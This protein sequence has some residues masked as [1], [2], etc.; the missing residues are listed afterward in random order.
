[1][2]QKTINIHE[3]FE[4][5]VARTAAALGKPVYFDFGHESDVTTALKEKAEVHEQRFPLVW[6]VMDFEE[7]R[8]TE[9]GLYADLSPIMLIVC[10]PAEPAD[11]MKTRFQERYDTILSPIYDELLNQIYEEPMFITM[12]SIKHTKVNRPFWNGIN[13]PQNKILLST[14]LDAIQI[15]NIELK[16]RLP[17]EIC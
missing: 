13:Q 7:R 8:G 10:T 4:R 3:I 14:V 15:K 2:M 17:I 11:S 5:V 16:V 9:L 1:M 6:L 12:P